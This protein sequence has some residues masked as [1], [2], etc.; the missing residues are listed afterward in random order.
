[1]TCFWHKNDRFYDQ[2]TIL[3]V[4]ENNV[5]LIRIYNLFVLNT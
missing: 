1:M 2:M 4:Y 5:K 3:E